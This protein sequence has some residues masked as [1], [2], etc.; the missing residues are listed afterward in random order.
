L[1][2]LSIKLIREN[3]VIC[4]ENLQVKNMVRNR[5]LAKSISDVSWGEF[6]RQL[7]Y[8]AEWYGKTVIEVGQYYASS[9]LCNKCGY[10]NAETKKLSVR[11]WI[12]P[13]CGSKHD[14]DINAAKNILVEGLK[15]VP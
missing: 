3:D 15:Q 12:C 8:K 14:R 5:K 11:V 9:Q 4:I 2:K 6:I 10:R 13:E 1:H 7:K